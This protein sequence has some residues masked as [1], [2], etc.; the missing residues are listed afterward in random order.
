M[1]RLATALSLSLSVQHGLAQTPTTRSALLGRVTVKG[2]PITRAKITLQQFADSICVGLANTKELN[3][4]QQAQ[5]K[6]CSKDFAV[7]VTKANG[8]YRFAS[9][10]TGYYKLLIDWDLSEKPAVSFP[11]QWQGDFRISYYQSRE[12]V[13]TYRAL[14]QG[15]IFRLTG[16][17]PTQSDF[18]WKNC[19]SP[20]C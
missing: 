1:W 17:K 9:V 10:P 4:E 13:A 19:S 20:K 18:D 6:A 14:A 8:A 12:T 2:A 3:D 5:L 16:T 7:A 11:I 15:P